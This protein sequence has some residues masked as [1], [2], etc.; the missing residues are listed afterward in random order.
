MLIY[1]AQAIVEA[2]RPVIAEPDEKLKKVLKEQVRE[3][4]ATKVAEQYETTA[5]AINGIINNRE[6]VD[7]LPK[8]AYD[9]LKLKAYDKQNNK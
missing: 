2:L 4:G 9:D 7:S 1:P 8:K 5:D 6:T 3:Q